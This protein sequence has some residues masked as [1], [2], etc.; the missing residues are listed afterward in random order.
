MATLKPV[1]YVNKVVAGQSRRAV[2]QHARTIVPAAKANLARHRRDGDHSIVL[3]RGRTDSFVSLQGP[4]A[5][6]VE[7]GHWTVWNGRSM[8]VPGL[9]IL[10]DAAGL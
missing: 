10:R 7:Q 5:L 2:N 8:Y 3:S 6:S 9:R 1:K 4:A